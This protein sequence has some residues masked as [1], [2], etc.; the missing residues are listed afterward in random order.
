MQITLTEEEYQ[1]A[2]EEYEG[3]C[4]ACGESAYGVEPDARNYECES[5]GKNQVFGAEELLMMGMISL[6]N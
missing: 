4:V 6:E 2:T 1:N 3:F 5:C